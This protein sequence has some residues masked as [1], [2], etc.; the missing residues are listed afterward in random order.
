[1][2]DNQDIMDLLEQSIDDLENLMT[3]KEKP[4]SKVQT[5]LNA[6]LAKVAQ[7]EAALKKL[8]LKE[9]KPPK[10]TKKT[11]PFNFQ[12]VEISEIGFF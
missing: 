12:D 3:N 2:K 10:P 4:I 9:K 11:D 7:Q 5:E 1:M 8:R 6:S